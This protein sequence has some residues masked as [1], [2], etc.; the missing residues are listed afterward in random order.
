[1]FNA[2]K[3][4][5]DLTEHAIETYSVQFQLDRL[6]PGV[7]NFRYDVYLSPAF[8]ASIQK[9]VR[10]LFY[11]H[12]K[13]KKY[14]NLDKSRS[15]NIE[16]DEFKRLCRDVLH[17][18]V[19]KAKSASEDQIDLLAQ[20][21]VV[22]KLS[23]ET[24]RQHKR[25]IEDLNQAAR[26]HEISSREGLDIYIQIKE[27]LS[28]IQ[29]NKKSLLRTVGEE[30]FRYFVEVQREDLKEMRGSV[31]GADSNLPDDFFA[32]PILRVENPFDDYFMIDEYVLLAHRSEDPDSYQ[33]FLI[34]IRSLFRKV[35]LKI[36]MAAPSST[37]RPDP[38]ATGPPPAS[39]RTG[40]PDP[41][42][43]Y[44]ELDIWLKHVD[45]VHTLFNGFKSKERY[46][47][48]KEQNETKKNIEDLKKRAKNQDRL[49]NFIY[50]KF[51]K[52]GL[53]KRIAASYEMKDVYSEYCPPLAPQQVLQYLI[54]PKQGKLI[55]DQLNR[56][57][58]F[59]GKSYSL[60]PL[61]KKI[62]KLKTISKQEKK[63]YLLQFLNDF[64]RYHRDFQNFLMLREA[65]DQTQLL[66]DKKMID[67]SRENRILYEFLLPDEE[68]PEV[69]P[70]INQVIIKADVRDSSEIILRMKEKGL[71]PASFFSLN[72][73]VPI[74]SILFEY[75]A[76]KVFIEGDAVIL[77]IFEQEDTPQGWYSVSR[78][79]GLAAHML[80]IVRKYNVVSRKHKL[81]VLELGIGIS[82][83]DGPPT[84][85]FDES[86]R[87]MISP[88]INSADRMSK[89]S[90]PLHN[91]MS[92]KKRPFNLY[93]FESALMGDPTVK[94]DVL[95]RY[96]VNGIELNAF[97][98]DK[99]SKEIHLETLVCD[100]PELREG[101]ITV[102]TGKY[103]TATGI[104]QRL[105]IREGRIPVVSS[106]DFSI[107][108]QTD[109]PYFEVC[110]HP[111]LFEY[112]ENLT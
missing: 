78:A 88:A 1:M 66:S 71:N 51:N 45:N 67:L 33:N 79:C 21:A 99:L 44:E 27:K 97:G 70:D 22:K 62:R 32:N 54:Q 52:A 19:N 60:S 94:D 106:N 107:V 65:L 83:Y 8:C 37:D 50:K 15:L 47:T 42:S 69:K 92:N 82:Y 23:Q 59:Y 16:E 2:F 75:G 109:T 77:S 3:L 68:A 28:D 110:T 85:L 98:F 26:K 105:V 7:D 30:L 80:D 34:L 84:F 103:P 90:K 104:Y 9:V 17:A 111:L 89:C 93:V 5:P 91:M 56:L 4:R 55:V 95:L 35:L 20:I 73:F 87:I 10:L 61:K 53:I 102:H 14:V 11:K 76:E 39:G 13:I 96:N 36:F 48:L 58:K 101:K 25:I 72:F 38:E 43:Q 108:Q 49:L 86:N 46:K 63:K 112:I 24:Q 100:L 12:A 57:K 29:Q 81:P 18:A 40:K 41:E 6:V 64:V 31:L 74:T